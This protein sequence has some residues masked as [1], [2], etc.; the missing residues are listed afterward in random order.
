MMAPILAHFD[1][2]RPVVIEAD[3]SDFMLGAI[4]SQRDDE[5]RLH[6]V[7]FH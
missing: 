5:N 2:Q 3:A 4:L 6:P 1:A 7:A